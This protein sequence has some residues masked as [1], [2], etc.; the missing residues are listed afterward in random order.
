MQNNPFKEFNET[1]IGKSM[2][3]AW[4][5]FVEENEGC[6]AEDSIETADFFA[7]FVA[8]WEQQSV[9]I[10]ELEQRIKILEK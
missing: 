2:M 3:V 6:Y 8:A 1:E 4:K 5:K 9:K 7:G 10:E